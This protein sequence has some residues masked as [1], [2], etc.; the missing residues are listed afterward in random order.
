ME[1]TSEDRSVAASL[2]IVGSLSTSAPAPDKAR[3]ASER[4]GLVSCLRLLGV[5]DQQQPLDAHGQQLVVL[6]TFGR[7]PRTLEDLLQQRQS[8]RADARERQARAEARES[9]VRQRR[10][11]Q[12]GYADQASQQRFLPALCRFV[13]SSPSSSPS[14][15][16]LTGHSLAHSD[17][18]IAFLGLIDVQEVQ[19]PLDHSVGQDLVHMS[20]AD[21]SSRPILH[22]G[23]QLAMSR[24]NAAQG[25]RDAAGARQRLTLEVAP[26]HRQHPSQRAVKRRM[27]LVLLLP[28]QRLEHKRQPLVDER[29]SRGVLDVRGQ[30]DGEPVQS[31]TPRPRKAKTKGLEKH[32]EEARATGARHG[33]D[34]PQKHLLGMQLD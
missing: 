27:Y 19:Q 10:V 24:T 17:A 3:E 34:D 8:C 4:H 29:Q 2:R 30:E 22:V 25:G 5:S 9:A 6:A 11:Q 32:V 13:R 16:T 12:P 20:H 23:K 33:S 1:H 31:E 21:R 26:Q 18:E 7:L 14:S 15:C 28:R